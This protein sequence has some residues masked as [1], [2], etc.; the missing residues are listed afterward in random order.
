MFVKYWRSTTVVLVVVVAVVVI[1]ALL[2]VVAALVR[3]LPRHGAYVLF[4]IVQYAIS[5]YSLPPRNKIILRFTKH[6]CIPLIDTHAFNTLTITVNVSQTRCCG[7]LFHIT[8]RSG[9]FLKNNP[10]PYEFEGHKTS[11]TAHHRTARNCGSWKL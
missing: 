2:I 7:D 11:P 10:V 4:D 6:A 1:V 3:V 8:L 9:A 5:S